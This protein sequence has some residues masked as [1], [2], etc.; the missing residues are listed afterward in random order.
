MKVTAH[1]LVAKVAEEMA[2]ETYESWAS[3][4]DAFYESAPDIKVW[5]NRN[6]ILFIDPARQSLGAML[7]MAGIPPEQKEMIHEAL[8]LD[9]QFALGRERAIRG[10]K[11]AIG[12]DS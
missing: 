11:N 6:W 3:R 1:K 9:N 10:A 7:G 8:V 5:V 12:L 2:C 4:A